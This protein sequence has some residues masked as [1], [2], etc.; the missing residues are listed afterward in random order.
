MLNMNVWEDIR[1]VLMFG[2]GL[3]SVPVLQGRRARGSLA[4]AFRA[5][6]GFLAVLFVV[7]VPLSSSAAPITYTVNGLSSISL[8]IFKGATMLGVTAG[9]LTG[10]ITLDNDAQTGDAIS[11]TTSPNMQLVLATPYG[12]YDQITTGAASRTSDTCH[13]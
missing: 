10:S 5:A 12:G 3:E 7:G 13:G 8:T 4:S 1:V 11:L 9:Q 2:C 6:L